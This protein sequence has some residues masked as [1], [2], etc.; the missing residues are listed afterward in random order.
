VKYFKSVQSVIRLC[1]TTLSATTRTEGNTRKY[2]AL[3][4]RS[5]EGRPAKRNRGELAER[6]R[7]FLPPH[8]I[9][10]KKGEQPIDHLPFKLK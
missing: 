8:S 7:A 2:S 1:P 10:Y 6:E 5:E 9:K 3:L 4:T